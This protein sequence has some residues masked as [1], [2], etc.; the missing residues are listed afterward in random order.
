MFAIRKISL[1]HLQ[2]NQVLNML[3]NIMGIVVQDKYYT[4]LI[5]LVPE[6]VQ[7]REALKNSI[8]VL[9]EEAPPALTEEERRKR[10]E[11]ELYE[12]NIR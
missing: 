2:D 9:P 10:A 1:I 4:E 5:I 6:P 12:K 11:D 7:H 3:V 8:R